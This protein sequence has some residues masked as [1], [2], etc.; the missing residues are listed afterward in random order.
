M[1]KKVALHIKTRQIVSNG[2]LNRQSFTRGNIS[3]NWYVPGEYIQMGQLPLSL[4]K[5]LSDI[6]LDYDVFVV[7][8][9]KTPIAWYFNENWTIPDVKYSVTT[10]HHQSLIRVEAHNPGFYRRF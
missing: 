6:N 3:A 8:S 2:M 1:E 4:Q 7:F 9:Y 5:E 10:T